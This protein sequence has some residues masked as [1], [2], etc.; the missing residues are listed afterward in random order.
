MICRGS[1]RL[2]SFH[3]RQNLTVSKPVIRIAGFSFKRVWD[4]INQMTTYYIFSSL[5]DRIV[6][7]F[8]HWYVGGF[9]IWSHIAISF[10]ESLDRKLAFKTTLRHIFHPMYQDRSFIGYILGFI[11]RTIR[12]FLGTII[13][14]TAIAVFAGLYLIWAAIPF[15]AVFEII[16]GFISK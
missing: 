4:K 1:R 11:F 16:S 10:L 15:Y 5:V 12:L 8:N 9:R 6:D 13:Y 3:A 14:G 7:F 2:D